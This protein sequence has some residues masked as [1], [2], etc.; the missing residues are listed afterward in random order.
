VGSYEGDTLVVDTIG[1][2]TRTFV[3]N[4]ET[5]HSDKLHTIERFRVT[6]GGMRMEVQL[7]RRRPGRLHARRGTRCSAI[8]VSSQVSPT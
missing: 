1:I 5:P 4:F 7:A 6:D 2:S 8:G 3:D